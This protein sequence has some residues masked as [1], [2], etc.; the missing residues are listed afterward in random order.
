MEKEIWLPVVDSDGKLLV[1]NTGRVKSTDRMAFNGKGFYH[2]KERI[3]KTQISR[4]GYEIVRITTPN[5]KK[6]LKVHRMVAIAFIDNPLGK[7]QVNHINGDKTDNRVVNLEWC[8]NSEN[9]KHAYATGLQD[10]TKYTPGKPR[11]SVQKINLKTGAV[12]EEY[13]SI[14]EAAHANG[15]KTPSNISSVCKGKK[16]SVG[17]FGWKYKEKK[18]GSDFNV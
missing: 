6:T 4:N 18:Y 16:K 12:I 17:G 7:E 9:Q 1:S 13:E 3:L 14:S 15:L 2:K 10:R 5:G 8:D 11:K